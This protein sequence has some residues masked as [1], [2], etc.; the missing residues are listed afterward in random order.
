ML[1]R[2][3]MQCSEKLVVVGNKDM[4]EK[5]RRWLKTGMVRF[6]PVRAPLLNSLNLD[7][8]LDYALLPVY[9][10]ELEVA[11]FDGVL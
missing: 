3:S 4:T 1:T 10:F 8:L 7:D 9:S 2:K 11:S 5:L 6:A